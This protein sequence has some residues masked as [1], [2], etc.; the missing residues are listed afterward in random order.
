MP[1]ELAST[2]LLEHIAESGFRSSVFTTY[3]CYFPFYE[4]VVLRRLMAAGC[5]HN[6]L[7]VDAT[8]CAEAFAVEELRPRRAGR[9]YTLIPVKVGGAFHPKL[10]LRFGKSKGSLLVGSHNVTLS[11]F[12][13]NDEVTNVFRLEG[14]ALRAGG[15][16]FRQAFNYLAQFVPT[17]LADV[18]E[19][20]EGVKLGVPWLDGPL[21]TGPQDRQLLTESSAGADLWSQ[22]APLIPK[23]L[24]TAFVG[25]PFF[26]PTL[27]MVRRLQRDMRPKRLVIGID[28]ASVEVD[29]AEAAKLEGV[30]WVNIAG[31]PQIPQRREGASR[32][33]HAKVFWFASK[34][35]EL[36][37]TGSANPSVA[38]F[39]AAPGAR[40][41]EAVVADR[42]KEAADRLDMEALLAAPAV[43]STEWN[44]VAARRKA[45]PPSTSEEPRRILVATPTPTGFVAQESLDVGLVLHG[46]GDLDA[47]LGGAVAREGGVIE[48]AD[49][50]RDGARY[51]EARAAKEH[52]LVIIHRTEDI[53]KNLG[54]DTRKAL[55]QALGA[56]EEDPTQLE[57]L[58]KLTEK[59]IFDSDDVV[60]TTPLRPGGAAG[61]DQEA[62]AAPVSLALEAA[63]RKSSSRRTRSLA[64]GDIVVLLDALMR[65]LGEGLPTNASPRPRSEEEEIGADE[66]EGGELAREAPDSEVLAKAC[67]GKVRRLIK[68]MEGQFELAN[69]PDRARRGIVQ[70]AAVLGVIR[71]LRFVEQRPEWKRMRHEL[72]DRADEWN[73]FQSAVLAVAW[74][75]EALAPRAEAEA[76]GEGFAELSMVVGL[77]AWLAWDVETD[78]AV[79]SQ[80]GGLEGLE[81]QQWYAVQLL[82]ALG[83]WLVDD[84]TAQNVL[85][86]SVAR[87]P[88]FRVDGERWLSVHRAAL[89]TFAIVTAAPDGLG[90]VGRRV[91]P[92]DLVVLHSREMPRVRVVLDVRPGSD[93]GKVVMLAPDATDG[94]RSFL[95]S[96]VATLAWDLG[97]TSA[98][99]AG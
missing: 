3:S 6:V 87:T 12:G 54:G 15:A 53:A 36:L 57:A 44:A 18:A 8:R 60:R 31:V 52:T 71:T 32:Y 67:R 80:R 90:Q 37:V 99:A 96:R 20:F 93:G 11:G 45:A 46:A 61:A 66:E 68:R 27:A 34:Q 63:G 79:A 47:P 73:L 40:N 64:S 74:G 55:R 81:D 5:T 14:A 95:A 35:D 42:T 69:A 50:V 7:M 76:D 56:L 49:A 30:E 82:A 75:P 84:S 78:I 26:D 29:P 48:A 28:P 9:D 59:V 85:E 92:G 38:A 43:T 86:E 13:L 65:R 25:G 91:R 88:R 1:G 16:P 70:L 24:T 62:A 94:E 22:V 17:Q 2:S 72:V 19:A 98:T 23:D 33:L 10:F 39:F 77:L 4:E 89:E 21:G 83:P 41:A 97:T 51:L 58:L